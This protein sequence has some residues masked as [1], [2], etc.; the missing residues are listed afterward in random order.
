MMP[1]VLFH[2]LRAPVASKL[3]G[4]TPQDLVGP[5]GAGID[6]CAER[7][8]QILAMRELIGPFG[9]LVYT[10]ADW[11]DEALARRSME[12]M[13]DHVMPRVNDAIK[14]DE[15]AITTRVAAGVAAE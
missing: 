15:A 14:A 3:Q 11:A 12:L 5:I 1:A 8:D 9:T 13:A 7:V 6:D 4:A 10:G 2:A